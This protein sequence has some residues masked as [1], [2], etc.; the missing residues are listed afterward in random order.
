MGRRLGTLE[1]GLWW[2]WPVRDVKTTLRR[3]AG[4]YDSRYVK[5]VAI[6]RR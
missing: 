5:F 3:I 4:G 6:G 1:L 2:L